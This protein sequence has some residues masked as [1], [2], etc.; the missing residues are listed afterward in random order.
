MIDAAILTSYGASYKKVAAGE[1]IFREGQ[2]AHFYHQLESGR[3]KWLT[4]N[5]DG[6]EF[7][8]D[9][10]EPVES[11]GEFPL[12]DGE[13]YAATAIADKDCVIL[14]L[15]EASFHQLLKD[16]P[17]YGF[18]FTKLMVQRLRFKFHFSK[19]IARHNP[20]STITA[21]LDHFKKEKH[22]ICSCCSKVQLTRQQIADMTGL[23]VET[24]IRTIR[25]LHDKGALKVD[26]GKVYC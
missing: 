7:I 2:Q 19:E 14:R 21:L 23:R 1:V 6:S 11:F 22:Y 16:H 18:A 5:D 13:P 10:I 4:I 8:H 12:F 20:E 3:V 26:R 17:H 24:V 25:N 9:I 15:H